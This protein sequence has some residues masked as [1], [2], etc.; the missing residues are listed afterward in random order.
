MSKKT[1]YLILFVIILGSFLL[2]IN[3]FSLAK[4][5][6][7]SVWNYYLKSKGFYFT[8]E[9]LSPAGIKNVNNVWT[10]ESVYFNIK[11]SL[12]ASVAS[13]FDISYTATCSIKTEGIYGNC[14]MNGSGTSSYNGTLSSY[15]RC[16]N[17]TGN[18]VD[19]SGLSKTDCE[20]GGYNYVTEEATSDLYF[21]ITGLSNDVTDLTVSV[22]V[23]STSP[24]QKT[25]IG[26]F[27]LHKVPGD[28]E[29]I[30]ALVNDKDDYYNLIITNSYNTNKCVNISWDSSKIYSNIGLDDMN[31]YITDDNGYIKSIKKELEGKNS[32]SLKYYSKSNDYI[33]TKESFEITELD[34]CN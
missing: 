27:I 19:V 34:S 30:S 5:V 12:N 22:T 26:D 3:G 31:S 7:N 9:D 14:L 2:L 21:D 10:G 32:I 28:D 11:N 33:I 24:Y 20:I 1:N 8:S 4:Y 18:G 25:L 16:V 23:K 13:E 29:E 15:Q 6:S 17:A